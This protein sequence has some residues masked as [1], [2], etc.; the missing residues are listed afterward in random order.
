MYGDRDVL[1]DQEL[2]GVHSQYVLTL[3][4]IPYRE[5]KHTKKVKEGTIS[6]SGKSQNSNFQL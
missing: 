4:K 2:T 6:Q 5:S 3:T 1:K